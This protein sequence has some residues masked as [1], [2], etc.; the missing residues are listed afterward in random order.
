MRTIVLGIGLSVAAGCAS[1]RTVDL[2]AAGRVRVADGG[3]AMLDVGPPQVLSVGNDLVVS[4][5][6]TRRPGFD[7]PVPGR[8]LVTVLSAD[9]QSVLEQVPTGWD[10]PHVPV[11]GDRRASYRLRYGYLP[12]DGST[13]RV[14]HQPDPNASDDLPGPAAAYR[15]GYRSTDRRPTQNGVRNEMSPQ[16]GSNARQR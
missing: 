1:T 7:G 3:S 13:V 14:A 12:P 15:P 4:G 5:T 6:V 10:P 8:L 9:G 11:D 2:A 16:Q